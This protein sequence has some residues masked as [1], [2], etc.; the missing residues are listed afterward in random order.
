MSLSQINQK[1]VKFDWG[2][3]QKQ[4]LNIEAEKR[5]CADA[6][7][8]ALPEGIAKI[9]IAYCDVQKKGFWAF[10]DARGEKK[11]RN[12]CTVFT[13]HK[14]LQHILDQKE[15]NMRATSLVRVAEKERETTKGSSLS[16]DGTI[17]GDKVMLK[18][19]PWKGGRYIFGNGG[20]YTSDIRT[21]QSVKKVGVVVTSLELHSRVGRSLLNDRNHGR[22]VKQL[23]RSRCFCPNCHGSMET[24]GAGSEFTLWEVG[25]Q[26]RKKYPHLFTK[27]APSSSAVVI[28]PI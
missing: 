12:K 4:F 26:F 28:Q 6:P 2:V 16:S 7:I 14:S 5:S 17:V 25:S 19:L 11:V 24:S 22:E 18:V 10:V 1:G 9:F 21:F 23:R 27:T 15:L 8:L 3:K 20:S 13:G